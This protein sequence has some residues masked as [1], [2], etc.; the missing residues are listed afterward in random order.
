M[1]I[2]TGR[3]SGCGICREQKSSACMSAEFLWNIPSIQGDERRHGVTQANPQRI[4]SRVQQQQN[5]IGILLLRSSTF[6]PRPN[7]L[8]LGTSIL[9]RSSMLS[10]RRRDVKRYGPGARAGHF[11][12]FFW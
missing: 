3:L 10:L 5:Y 12:S 6:S 1:Q 8:E 7:F 9:A 11:P 2:E 4:L